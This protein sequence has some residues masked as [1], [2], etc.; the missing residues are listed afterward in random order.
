MI[1]EKEAV[2]AKLDEIGIEYEKY[3][4]EAMYS[5]ED[6]EPFDRKI[7]AMIVKNY[8]L[9]TRRTAQ[10]Y[11]C[12]V[13]PDA[14]FNASDISKQ[15]GS[16]RLSFGSAEMMQQYLHVYPGAVSPLGLIFDEAQK[17]RLLVDKKL[18]DADRLAFHPCDNTATVAMRGCDFFEKFLT[19]IGREYVTVEIHDFAQ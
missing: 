13:R 16:S 5:M 14:H 11:L 17:V 3:E 2:F 10:P 8:F 19:A 1:S 15:A 6:C 18:L 4:H 9:S 12:L 7:G